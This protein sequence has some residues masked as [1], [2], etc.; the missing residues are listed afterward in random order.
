[1]CGVIPHF[2]AEEMGVVKTLV[3]ARGLLVCV[4]PEARC[5]LLVFVAPL[6]RIGGVL[7]DC[8][9]VPMFRVYCFFFVQ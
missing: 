2:A 1:M 3:R 9:T 6:K 5:E 8:D 7:L 4:R